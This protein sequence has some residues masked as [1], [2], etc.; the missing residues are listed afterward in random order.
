MMAWRRKRH[1]L[2]VITLLTCVFTGIGAVVSI[3]GTSVLRPLPFDR[4]GELYHTLAVYDGMADAW[5]LEDLERV[6]EHLRGTATFTA[7]TVGNDEAV[8]YRG[9]TTTVRVIATVANYFKLLGISTG[10]SAYGSMPEAAIISR[11]LAT[12][13]SLPRGREV[14]SAI[15]VGEKPLTVAAVID[16]DKAYP[17]DVDVWYVAMV[18]SHNWMGTF[19]VTAPISKDAFGDRISLAFRAIQPKPGNHRVMVSPLA[20]TARPQMAGA[21][22]MLIA[23]IAIFSIIAILNYGL[24]GIGDAR[25]RAQEFAVRVAVGGTRAQVMR[26]LFLDQLALVACAFALAALVLLPVGL[27]V[28]GAGEL[29]AVALHLP[30]TLWAA[31]GGMI[32]LLVLAAILPTR[33]SASTPE[34]DVLRRVSARST[35]FE[36]WWNRAFVSLQ[37]GVTAF[38]LVVGTVAVVGVAR[39][40]R[41]SYG[42]DPSGA[43]LGR[44]TAS[45]ARSGPQQVFM[46]AREYAAQLE[47]AYPKNAT[48]WGMSFRS[49]FGGRYR[50]ATEESDAP[51]TI[52]RIPWLSEDVTPNF[53]DVLGIR[54]VEGRA[55]RASDDAQSEP[56][57]ILSERIAKTL[58]GTTRA[59]GKRVR[60]GENDGTWRTV[61]GI[62]ADAYPLDETSFARQARAT[63]WATGFAYRPLAQTAP[64]AA[65]A[66]RTSMENGQFIGGRSGF[67][68][69]VRDG[70][71]EAIEKTLASLL[72]RVGPGEKFSRIGPLERFL[73]PSGEVE[74]GRSTMQLIL[75][76][77]T[78]GL[79]LGIIGA[80]VLIDDVVRSRTNEFGIRRALGAPATNLIT[81]AGRETLGAGVAGVLVGGLLGARF[82]PFVAMWLRGT[83]YWKFMPPIPVDWSMAIAATA[84]LLVILVLGTIARAAGAARLDPVVALRAA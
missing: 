42:F 50:F 51:R 61:V 57:I 6:S 58:W 37:F 35:P 30:L 20:Q 62:A 49:M 23:G 11:R 60:F 3:L 7:A 21:Q 67:F 9:D 2:S 32:G 1:A 33:V 43:I 15:R 55:F 44:V 68:V 73:D 84:G 36:T 16:R 72:D 14:G 64:E 28:Y 71:A 39:D 18:P 65:D 78:C 24:L 45:R 27:R 46:L 80:M 31:I 38:L 63:P 17:L 66:D 52:L 22:R 26:G 13:L 81:L 82:G 8:A 59:V 53:F 4:P 77:T 48:L 5:S 12:R 76:F 83:S 40:R 41:T 69:L 70:N 25:R 56:V 75:A 10:T 34:I 54:I 79:I 29:R 74:H 19:R 47:R